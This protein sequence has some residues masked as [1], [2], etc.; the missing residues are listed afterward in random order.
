MDIE[1]KKE[2][3][4]SAPAASPRSESAQK[5]ERRLSAHFF[6]WAESN[7][8]E[9]VRAT[10]KRRPDFG[11][12]VGQG[13]ETALMACAACGAIEALRELIP[14]S[15]LSARNRDGSTALEIAVAR[16]QEEAVKELLIPGGAMALENWASARRSALITR[17]FGAARIIAERLGVYQERAMLE[18]DAP[19][20]KDCAQRRGAPGPRL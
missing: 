8:A 11:A 3:W 12:R 6:A 20:P 7:L 17:R 18:A 13:G 14:Y 4:R 2:R 10:L 16:G 15:D 1:L 9:Q 5:A 19:E